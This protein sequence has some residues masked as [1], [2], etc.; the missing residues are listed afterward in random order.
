MD[1]FCFAEWTGSKVDAS[2]DFD[3]HGQRAGNRQPALNTVTLFVVL[4]RSLIE[5]VTCFEL[6]DHD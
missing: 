4:L 6:A 1:G 2:V 3:H 5:Y